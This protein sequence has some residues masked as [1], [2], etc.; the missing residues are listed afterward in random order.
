[1]SFYSVGLCQCRDNTV[2]PTCERCADGFYGNPLLGTSGDC[3]PCPCPHQSSCAVI[4]DTGEVVCTDCPPGQRGSLNEKYIFA[5]CP[6]LLF[7]QHLMHKVFLST[8]HKSVTSGRGTS[9][10]SQD[11]TS[12][13]L[14]TLRTGTRCEMCDDGFHGD[15]RGARGQWKP[16]RPCQCSGNV[17]PNAVGV[18]DHATGRCLKCLHNTEGDRCELCKDGYYG[19]ALDRETLHKCKREYLRGITMFIMNASITGSNTFKNSG[20]GR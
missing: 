14:F 3:Q 9:G 4:P 10:I 7:H 13:Y 11:V 15:P 6:K 2:G 20:L 8:S 12:S 18:C 16:C 5:M 17:D 1:M 19:N